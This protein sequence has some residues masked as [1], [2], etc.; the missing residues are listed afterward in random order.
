M[1]RIE[2]MIKD[3]TRYWYPYVG[4]YDPCPPMKV[5]TFIVPPNLFIR[6]QP[7]QLPQFPVREAL[8]R[9]TLWP[10]FYSPYPPKVMND[11]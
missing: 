1:E 11:E 5:K 8:Y 2:R 6:F 7:P 4:I 9:G 10:I 3:Q